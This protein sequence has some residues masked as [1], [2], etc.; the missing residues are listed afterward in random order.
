VKKEYQDKI[1]IIFNEFD[2]IVFV[3]A[4]SCIT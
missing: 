2:N 4:V 3:Y 1:M